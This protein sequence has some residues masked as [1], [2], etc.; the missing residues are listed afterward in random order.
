M[1]LLLGAL[2]CGSDV[3]ASTTTSSAGGQGGQDGTATTSNGGQGGANTTSTG[4][5]GGTGGSVSFDGPCEDQAVATPIK[6]K[7]STVDGSEFVYASPASP[8]G[9]M[10]FFHGGG[11]YKEDNLERRVDPVLIATEAINQ[12][13]AVASLDSVAHLDT[14]PPNYKWSEDNSA[15]NKDVVNAKSMIARLTDP[16]DLNAAPA[17]GPIVLVGYSNGGSMASR[18]AQHTTVAAVASYISNASAF[19]SNGALIPPLVMI[20]GDNDPG[21]AKGS[22]K[23]LYD[24][25]T[26]NGGDALYIVNKAE[27]IMRGLFMRIPGVDCEMSKSIG[28]SLQD[29]A[30]L[31]QDGKL[32]NNPKSDTSWSTSLSSEAQTHKQQIRDVLIE[33]YAEHS[34]S[35]D[36]NKKVFE[37]IEMHAK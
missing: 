9:L 3:T 20:P 34:P 36:Q 23:D 18:L 33:A 10:L 12:G 21:K 17:N 30:W 31:K 29:A 22:N 1:T 37:F 16:N 2:G 14:N 4:G 19:H 27:T 35:S 13:Y 15:N 11:G 7:M 28:Q 8:K 25:I 26:S 24:S 5:Q 32:A 6:T